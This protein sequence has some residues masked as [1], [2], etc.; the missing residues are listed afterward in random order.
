MDNRQILIL[1]RIGKI[2]VSRKCIDSVSMDR[3][4]S[5]VGDKFSITLID[6]PDANI[7][8]DLE[9][10]MASGYRDITLRYGDISENELISFNGTI[11]DYTSTFV[12]NIKKLTVTGIA[13]RYTKNTEGVASYTYNIDWNSYFN[14]REDENI[15]YGA[16]NAILIRNE[17]GQ[18][19]YELEK[20]AKN[21]TAI[22]ERLIRSSDILNTRFADTRFSNSKKLTLNGPGGSADIPIPDCF[23]YTEELPDDLYDWVNKLTS[24]D[25]EIQVKA[26]KD[27]EKLYNFIKDPKGQFWGELQMQEDRVKPNASQIFNYAS[28]YLASS[29]YLHDTKGRGV[30][31]GP[32]TVY[33]RSGYDKSLKKITNVTKNVLQ[34]MWGCV[35]DSLVVGNNIKLKDTLFVYQMVVNNYYKDILSLTN[36]TPWY[37]IT[38]STVA[39][40][41]GNVP[42]NAD[43]SPIYTTYHLDDENGGNDVSVC[44]NT[45]GEVVAF[46]MT[47]GNV[48]FPPLVAVT[49][50]DPFVTSPMHRDEPFGAGG[51]TTLDDRNNRSIL[52]TGSYR[53]G[54]QSYGYF[55]KKLYIKDTSNNI[56]LYEKDDKAK[57]RGFVFPSDPNSVNSPNYLY[58]QANPAAPRSIYG[59]AGFL[60]SGI[61]VDISYIVKKLADLEGW[62]YRDSDIVQTDLLVNSDAFIMQ[63]QTAMDFIIDNLVPRAITPIGQYIGID[64]KPVVA[65]TPQGGFYP[66]FDKDGYFHFQPL[67]QESIKT[68]TLDNIGYNMPNSPVLSFQVN[69]K[70]TAFYT[71]NNIEY[72][73]LNIVTGTLTAESGTIDV[74][75]AAQ[76]N[77]IAK[78]KGHN[79]TF[80]AWLGLTYNDVEK[81]RTDKDTPDTLFNKLT[82]MAKTALVN[83]PST[84]LMGSPVEN[85]TEVTAKLAEAQKKIWDTVIK[86]TLSM[87]GNTKVCPAS[88]IKI[89]NMIKGANENGQLVNSPQKHPSSGTYLILSMQDKI[90]S[91]GYIQNLN[92]LRYTDDVKA[93]INT[94][95]IDYSKGATFTDNLPRPDIGG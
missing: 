94:Y 76:A 38:N 40:F 51:S 53:S 11:W 67:T 70:G 63:N 5:D 18:K 49:Q 95:K 34:S 43:G 29:F 4:F 41:Y 24:E 15:Q 36:V 86:A 31:Y 79:D 19:Y 45:D 56:Y 10:Y 14:L 8:Y 52:N 77:A 22:A 25:K 58:I 37:N 2:D 26:A 66:F 83:T 13:S 7:L 42:K 75:S 68:L 1:L 47:R 88:N 55:S 59:S 44:K 23:Y 87:W 21:N 65:K 84:L 6:S 90:D 54:V 73:P 71:F 39:T 93:S 27:Y 78:T 20:A 85:S 28:V 16:I 69:T 35:F 74:I 92:L 72:K 33:D 17:I 46:Y 62:K 80:D 60:N 89:T 12:G 30:T 61:G 91:S 50:A 82:N 3:N 9:L 32:E 64:G 57:L 81:V 48:S